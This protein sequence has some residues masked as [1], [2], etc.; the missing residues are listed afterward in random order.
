MK[1]VFTYL[2]VIAFASFLANC[3]TAKKAASKAAKEAAIAEKK[4]AEAEAIA[5]ANQPTLH[6][7]SDIA[8]ML[9]V[10][11]APCH[12]PPGG[13]KDPLN[14]YAAVKHSIEHVIERVKLAPSAMGFMPF[15]SKKPVLSAD[16]IKTLEA[17]QK[18]G[19]PE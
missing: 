2:L 14:T 13:N 8:P 15:Q 12:F 4:A 19:M 10:S 5:K 9:K 7:A 3:N 11:C 1:K 6:Y 17:W 16:Q 18:A